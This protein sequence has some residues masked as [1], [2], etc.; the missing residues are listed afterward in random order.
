M[1][2]HEYPDEAARNRDISAAGPKEGTER[3]GD[4]WADGPQPGTKCPVP[5]GGDRTFVLVHRS[6]QHGNW[7]LSDETVQ[8]RAGA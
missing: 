8:R 7:A 3:E 1:K 4:I 2:W 6:A 5:C